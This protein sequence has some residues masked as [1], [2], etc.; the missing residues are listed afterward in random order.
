MPDARADALA[1]LRTFEAACRR[2][3]F[4]EGQRSELAL[5]RVLGPVSATASLPAPVTLSNAT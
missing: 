1:W 4:E 3:D 2:R 5:K